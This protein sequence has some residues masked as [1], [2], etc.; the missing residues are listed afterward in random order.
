MSYR[1]KSAVRQTEIDTHSN[2]DQNISPP[3]ECDK[4][5]TSIRIPEVR[6]YYNL[7]LLCFQSSAT[8]LHGTLAIRVLKICPIYHMISK[9]SRTV[10]IGMYT[11]IKSDMSWHETSII[12][13]IGLRFS[14]L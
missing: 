8:Y 14:H 7:V 4:S 2:A 9:L 3:A 13:L 5:R 12:R 11:C 1:A 6:K 10:I